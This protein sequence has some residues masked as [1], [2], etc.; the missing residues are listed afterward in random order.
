LQGLPFRVS[1]S[2]IASFFKGLGM[3]PR[4]VR[5]KLKDGKKTGHAAV[6]FDSE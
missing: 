1:D 3:V 2:E 4:S 6:L 5:H